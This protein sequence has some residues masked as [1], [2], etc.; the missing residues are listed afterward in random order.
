VAANV[1]GAVPNEH[2]SDAPVTTWI[3][4]ATSSHRA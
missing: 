3:G 2:C 4:I 1:E